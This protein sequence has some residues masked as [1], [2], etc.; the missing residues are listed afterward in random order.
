MRNF[1]KTASIGALIMA[2]ALI[3]Y[4]F[5]DLVLYPSGGFPTDD[6]AVVVAGADILRVGHWLKF[7]Y[8]IGIALLTV[9]LHA[10][11]R[12]G[13][14]VLAQLAMLAGSAAA[15]LFIA[16]GM[17]GLRILAV[18]E[19]TFAANRA[20]AE[21]TILLRTVTIAV[22]DAAIFAGGWFLLLTSIAGLR[23]NTLPRSVT[24]P[25]VALGALFAVEFVTPEP[26]DL[27]A[28]LLA[29]A[30]TLW[31]A[32]VLWRESGSATALRTVEA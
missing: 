28:P 31:A 9:G 21:T 3:G 4:A 32:I 23:T 22:F 8:A 26:F 17:I 16:S 2:L 15:A 19:Q 12:E 20:E 18:A 5:Y 7:G 29:I 11:I 25:G 27:A 24:L 13:T 6:F 14:P 10:R 30:W 1:D